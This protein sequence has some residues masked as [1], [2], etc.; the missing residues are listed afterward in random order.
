MSCATYPES[1]VLDQVEEE[2]QWE[3]VD[4][5]SPGNRIKAVFDL[6]ESRFSFM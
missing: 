5:G 3:P 4:P 2:N 1:S 6:T